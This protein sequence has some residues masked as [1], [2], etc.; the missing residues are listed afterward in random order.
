MG[1]V[2]SLVWI[3]CRQTSREEAGLRTVSGYISLDWASIQLV[4]LFWPIDTDHSNK[5]DAMIYIPF[6]HWVRRYDSK[7]VSLKTFTRDC[8][9][10]SSAHVM[11]FALR[12]GE[13]T[14]LITKQ[15]YGSSEINSN[16]YD[17]TFKERRRK[18]EKNVTNGYTLHTSYLHQRIIR[19]ELL[20]FFLCRNV[21]ELGKTSMRYNLQTLIYDEPALFIDFAVILS[22]FKWPHHHRYIKFSHFSMIRT[23]FLL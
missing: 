18:V 8:C 17:N 9:C 16:L 1:D 21:P 2:L 15:K 10:M 19:N 13:R 7:S 14:S 6:P 23:N 11:C 12:N 20:L 5:H 4:D 22:S 3:F